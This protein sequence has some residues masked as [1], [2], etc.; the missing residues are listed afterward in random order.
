MSEF[1][2]F[3]RPTGLVSDMHCASSGTHVRT[4][5]PFRSRPLSILPCARE[6]A[7]PWRN[8][9]CKVANCRKKDLA[10]STRLHGLSIWVYGPCNAGLSQVG[11]PYGIKKAVFCHFA[12]RFCVPTVASFRETVR[13]AVQ[14]FSLV[15]QQGKAGFCTNLCTFGP[16]LRYRYRDRRYVQRGPS[17][18][19]RRGIFFGSAHSHGYLCDEKSNR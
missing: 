4:L 7:R 17:S 11:L 6:D 9:F 12:H 2:V 19:L 14:N 8:W 10:C 13:T 16:V 1:S 18:L 5:N 3:G 15:V